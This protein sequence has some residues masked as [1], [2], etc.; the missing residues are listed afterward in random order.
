MYKIAT[1]NLDRPTKNRIGKH[2][3]R[4]QRI[5]DQRAQLWVL[6]ETNR[7]LLIDGF[8]SIATE[9]P[10]F[11]GY[12]KEEA[13]AA[14]H[15]DA[16]LQAEAWP[17]FDPCFAVCARFA[18]SPLGPLIV[19]GSIITYHMDGVMSGEA[20]AWQRHQEATQQHGDDW[21]QLRRDYPDH[22][23]VVAGDYNQA[24]DG[25]GRYRNARSTALLRT[26]F[27]DAGLIC[28]TD[29][30]FRARQGLSRHSVDHIA[31]SAAALQ[32]WQAEATAW[33][34]SIPNTSQLSDHNGVTVKLLP[35]HSDR[36][37]S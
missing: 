37:S 26:A 18:S 31:I 5:A 36:A 10:R 4:T 9:R 17:T 20:K 3:D 11:P 32:T 2:I 25:A 23:L 21:R 15:H 8:R 34:S 13:Y 19:Y 7:N 30:N 12:G 29:A 24:L 22:T 14:I 28:L 1:W 6:T 27:Q 35:L 33:E 16:S